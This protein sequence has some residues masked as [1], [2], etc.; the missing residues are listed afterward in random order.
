MQ[1]FTRISEKPINIHS[2]V[3]APDVVVV[4]DPSLLESVDVAEGLKEDGLL[5]VNTWKTA[6]EV[7][8]KC[9][10][11]SATV[12][13]VGATAIALDS[14]GLPMPNLPMLG[15]LLKLKELVDMEKL[16][17]GIRKKMEHKIGE[18]KTRANI[19]GVKKA[20]EEVKT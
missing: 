13:T 17:K 10:C 18:E 9:G 3:H 6:R 14:L 7:R 15:A 1:A 19:E 8:E 5:L 16:V 2:G 12:A 4:L 20:Y 11:E